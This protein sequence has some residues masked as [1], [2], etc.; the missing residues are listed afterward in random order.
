MHL[1]NADCDYVYSDAV[2]ADKHLGE[3]IRNY[4]ALVKIPARREIL[5]EELG[6]CPPFDVCEV[7]DTVEDMRMVNIYIRTRTMLLDYGWPADFRRDDFV[8]DYTDERIRSWHQDRLDERN[9]IRHELATGD[10]NV[11][12]HGLREPDEIQLLRARSRARLADVE[13]DV[14][15]LKLREGSASV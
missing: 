3:L 8:R 11:D 12:T 4:K 15:L 1:W 14:K 2:A 13:R 6:K 5:S 7:T 9:Q 10:T